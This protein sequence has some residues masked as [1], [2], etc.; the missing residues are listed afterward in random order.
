ML[1]HRASERADAHSELSEN[2]WG[3]QIKS[4]VFH[5]YQLIKD[6]RTGT[7]KRDVQR[8]LDGEL[9]DFLESSVMHFRSV[10]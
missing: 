4:Y 1:T 8:V 5:P 6:M 7:E 3:S 2:G 10:K 9:D